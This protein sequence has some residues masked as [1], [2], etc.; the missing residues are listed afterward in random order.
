MVREL[1]NPKLHAQI[2]LSLMQVCANVEVIFIPYSW[3]ELGV[4]FQCLK[5]DKLALVGCTE[6]LEAVE[7]NMAH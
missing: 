7:A 5:Y 4:S 3:F 6:V 2:I 1:K